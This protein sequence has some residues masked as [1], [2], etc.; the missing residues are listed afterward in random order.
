[1]RITDFGLARDV[2]ELTS[3]TR[4]GDTIGTPYYM[5]PEQFQGRRDLD[6]RVDV[7]ALG[8][9][10]YECLTGRRPFEAPTTPQVAEMVLHGTPPQTPRSLVQGIPPALEA[11]CLRALE[12]DPRARTPS[13]GAMVEELER[14]LAGGADAA[15]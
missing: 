12:R 15:R 14:L 9:I 5:S 10:L 1:P 2:T 3:L 8:V 6:Q 4:T 7:W 11:I 13:A